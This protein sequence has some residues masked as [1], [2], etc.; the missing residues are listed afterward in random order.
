MITNAIPRNI[1]ARRAPIRWPIFHSS[2]CRRRRFGSS[3]AHQTS[4]LANTND[5]C[6]STCT[7]ALSSAPSN[8]N[9]MCQP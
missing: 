6:W 2:P 9:A 7:G 4:T 3:G 5:Q 8:M 1:P